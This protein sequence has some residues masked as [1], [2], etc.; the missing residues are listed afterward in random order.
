MFSTKYQDLYNSVGYDNQEMDKM[1]TDLGN[2]VN[3]SG[4]DGNAF[5]TQQEV[6]DAIA[7]FKPGKNDGGFGLS[8]DHF[9]YAGSCF[10]TFTTML[11]SAIMVHGT[12]PKVLCCSR[13]IP[14]PKGKNANLTDS[15]NYRGI[16]LSSIF[17]RLVDLIIIQRYGNKLTTCEQQFSFKS[18]LSANMCTLM[19][20][21]AI[22]Y[23][24][25]HGGSVYCVFLD[26]TKAFDRVEYCKLFKLLINRGLPPICLRLLLNMYT[27]HIISIAWNNI[28]SNAFVVRNGIKQG[29]ILSPLLFCIY[30]DELLLRLKNA[31]IGCW[32]GSVYVGALAYADDLSLLAPTIG[33][34]HSMLAICDSYAKEFNVIFN[35]SKTKCM[36]LGDKFVHGCDKDFSPRFYIAGSSIDIG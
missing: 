1:R 29:G 8:T 31:G 23:Y 32:I 19:L 21:E 5:I 27:S 28:V 22:T 36:C 30:F 25:N 35:A 4:I 18:K 16:T 3:T 26:A 7:K 15:N 11:L 17:V 14:I 13:L 20:K 9:M 24:C 33:A 6:R 2:L 12:V 34:M 10:V